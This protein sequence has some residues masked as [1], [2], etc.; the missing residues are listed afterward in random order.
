MRALEESLGDFQR[1]G[2]IA[3]RLLVRVSESAI[4]SWPKFMQAPVLVTSIKEI[5]HNKNCN[6]PNDC[7]VDVQIRRGNLCKNMLVFVL[8][9]AVQKICHPILNPFEPLPPCHQ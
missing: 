7:L 2:C 6:E 3:G 8:L 4:Y 5:K 1:K 9:G